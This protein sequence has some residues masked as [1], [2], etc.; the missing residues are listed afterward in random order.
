MSDYSTTS[1]SSITLVNEF[2]LYSIKENELTHN[3][4]SIINNSKNINQ[5]L[6]QYHF[7]LE[8]TENVLNI[9]NVSTSFNQELNNILLFMSR[10]CCLF[11]FS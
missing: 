5:K 1:V 4:T 9:F 11:L 6:D 3:Y 10:L 2:C 8:I 7:Q